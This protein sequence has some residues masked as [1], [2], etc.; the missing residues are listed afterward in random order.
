MSTAL[1]VFLVLLG[2]GLVATLSWAMGHMESF[3]HASLPV[4]EPDVEDGLT[5]N[6]E[7]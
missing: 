2:V 4:H 7:A 5:L 1:Q 6:S 3:L